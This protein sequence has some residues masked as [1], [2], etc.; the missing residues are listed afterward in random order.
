MYENVIKVELKKVLTESRLL[1]KVYDNRIKSYANS[2][3]QNWEEIKHYFVINTNDDLEIYYDSLN[4][5]L[6]AEGY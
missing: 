6:S 5:F 1:N 4:R 3:N 2:V